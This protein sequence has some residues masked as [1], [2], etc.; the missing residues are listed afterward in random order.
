MT[1]RRLMAGLVPVAAALAAAPAAL[2]APP[3]AHLTE[4]GGAPFP[5][6]HFI[7]TLSEGH[8]LRPGDVRVAENGRPVDGLRVVP[9]SARTSAVVVAIDTS[10]SM[11]GAPLKAAMAAARRF[12][13]GRPPG[14][15]SAWCS[16]TRR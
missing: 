1:V 15:G 6:K 16:S 13:A 9:A 14:S 8:V 11:R 10:R 4:A 12:A 7:L 3:A 2:A 5:A